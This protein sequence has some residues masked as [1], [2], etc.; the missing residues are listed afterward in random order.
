MPAATRPLATARDLVEELRGGDVLPSGR[1]TRRLKA[2][3]S[4]CSRAVA[5]DVVG[6]V[7]GRRRH[8]TSRAW[9]TRARS[10]PPRGWTACRYASATRLLTQEACRWD[11]RPLASTGSAAAPASGSGSRRPW[12][13]RPRPASSSPPHPA[14]VMAV[15]ADFA[16]YP[17]VGPGREE[18]RVGRAGRGGRPSRCTSSSTPPRSRTPTRSA[19]DWHG[20][21]SVT[22]TWSR[23]RCSRRWTAPTSCATA[24][25]RHRGDLPAG[26]RHRRSR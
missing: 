24:G 1:S 26:G 22:W 15:I 16:S 23:A 2:T 9:S 7:A 3:A 25:R 6:E 21:A 18:G 17:A 10:P 14:A 19:Y 4:A 12:P 13:S 5:H 20:D 11:R 8:R